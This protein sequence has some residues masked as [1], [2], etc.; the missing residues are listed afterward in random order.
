MSGWPGRPAVGDLR[1]EREVRDYPVPGYRRA[2]RRHGLYGLVRVPHVQSST[3]QCFP[4][5]LSLH[6]GPDGHPL[7]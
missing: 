2:R 7:P 3:L 4:H 5:K 1:D 6:N